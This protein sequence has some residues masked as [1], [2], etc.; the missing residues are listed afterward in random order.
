[1]PIL[2]TLDQKASLLKN[3]FRQLFDINQTSCWHN[4]C[5]YP[6]ILD[7]PAKAEKLGIASE[8]LHK[9]LMLEQIIF[10]AVFG[11]RLSL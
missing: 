4:Y 9:R 8:L 1:M 10:S 3:I 2:E 7:I 6:D 11:G 5:N